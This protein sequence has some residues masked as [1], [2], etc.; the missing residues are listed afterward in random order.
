MHHKDINLT[1][2]KE[3]DKNDLIDKLLGSGS[4][5]RT[6]ELIARLGKFEYF[7]LRH[8]EALAEI[9]ELNDQVG[10][11]IEDSDVSS[12]YRQLYNKYGASM[13]QGPKESLESALGVSDSGPEDE[14]PF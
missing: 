7:S 9:P 12:F 1:S 5:M 10:W 4:F 6:H 13:S 14:F 3:R 8:A 11:I 2:E